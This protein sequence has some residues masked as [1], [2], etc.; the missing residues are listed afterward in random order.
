MENENNKLPVAQVP[1]LLLIGDGRLA[2]HLTTYFEQLGLGHA[3]WSRRGHAEGRSPELRALIHSGTRALLAI[4]DGAIDP[5]VS[6]HPELQDA[7]RIHFSGPLLT[8]LATCAHPLFSF[9]SALYT[10]DLYERIPFVIDKGAPPLESLIPGLPNPAFFIDPERR[11]RYHALCVLAGN[12]TTLLWRK[13]F[14]ELDSEF[15]IAPEQALPYLESVTRAL[16]RPGA[17]LSGP[18][19]RGD[20][21]TIQ[22]NL[23]ALQGDP[24]DDVYRAFLA[25]YER[26]E[27]LSQQTGKSWLLPS[28]R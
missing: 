2:R 3:V 26:Q 24:F 20:H 11:P 15:G 23:E 8:P 10:R 9:A 13:F 4:S 18:L 14:Y 16:A 1:E 19:S 17:P 22:R 28:E 21:A 6:S 12:F 5:F 27:R 25:A 7:I